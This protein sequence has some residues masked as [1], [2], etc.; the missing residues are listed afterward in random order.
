MK[1]MLMFLFVAI[2]IVACAPEKD[3]SVATPTQESATWTPAP[4]QSHLECVLNAGARWDRVCIVNDY[5]EL[6]GTPKIVN[7]QGYNIAVPATYSLYTEN[8]PFPT[9]CNAAGCTFRVQW[10][11]P[12]AVV[13]YEN[14]VENLY[15]NQCYI[16]K[17]AWSGQIKTSDGKWPENILANGYRINRTNLSMDTGWIWQEF[18]RVQTPPD[19]DGFLTAFESVI[20]LKSTTRNP[21][22]YFTVGLRVAWGVLQGDSTVTLS[23]IQLIAAPDAYCSNGYIEF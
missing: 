10:T 16:L 1:K 6:E 14:V 17:T 12:S 8:R 5:S 11:E 18:P 13:A 21:S 22:L 2:V 3:T 20:P 15:A 23:R 19:R 7:V 9:G 4:K